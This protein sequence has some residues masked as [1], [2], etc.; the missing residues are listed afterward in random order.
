MEHCDLGKGL[1]L[2]F[3]SGCGKEGDEAGQ[4]TIYKLEKKEEGTSKD[5]RER[6]LEA[7]ARKRALT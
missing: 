4:L 6:S 5:V 3:C 7:S 2:L 1:L